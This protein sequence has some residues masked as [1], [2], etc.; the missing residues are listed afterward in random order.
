MKTKSLKV[1]Q[2][3]LA[4]V[5][6]LGLCLSFA[7]CGDGQE[8]GQ[9]GGQNGEPT[10][11]KTDFEIVCDYIAE[12]G[13]PNADVAD[14]TPVLS[15]VNDGGYEMHIYQDDEL[16]CFYYRSNLMNIKL[17]MESM[18]ESPVYFTFYISGGQADSEVTPA[19]FTG[20]TDELEFFGF[21]PSS[22]EKDFEF[23]ILLS[24]FD[25]PISLM[26]HYSNELLAGAGYDMSD[27]G[28]RN[29]RAKS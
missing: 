3:F 28:F 8:S 16:I 9:T 18:D 10:V 23:S 11:E 14:D 27:F 24:S 13:K 7:A 15:L 21:M 26:M 5:F 1:L 20:T 29:F 12:N 19:K 6:A 17:E 4:A 22:C 25:A 2:F